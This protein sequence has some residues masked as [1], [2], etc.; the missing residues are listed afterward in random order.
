MKPDAIRM[1][2]FFGILA[3]LTLAIWGCSGAT[4][5]EVIGHEH[6]KAREVTTYIPAGNGIMIPMVTL[7]APWWMLHLRN[8]DEE[9]KVYVDRE[10]YEKHP[11][12]SWY[13]ARGDSVR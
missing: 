1:I 2:L 11:L 7:K 9:G 8:G 3:A 12:G 13:G 5:G 10:V 6:G 4:S